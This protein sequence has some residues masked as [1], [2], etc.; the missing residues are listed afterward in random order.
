M[1]TINP[2]GVSNSGTLFKEEDSV[3]DAQLPIVLSFERPKDLGKVV[4]GSS[5]LLVKI[6]PQGVTLESLLPS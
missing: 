3:L 4:L 6:T 1:L 5:V 2:A